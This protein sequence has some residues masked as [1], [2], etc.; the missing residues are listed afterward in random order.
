MEPP[1]NLLPFPGMQ[2]IVLFLLLMTA[3]PLPAVSGRGA[4]VSHSEWT[5]P[6]PK[7]SK[8]TI[9]ALDAAAR[10]ITFLDEEGNEHQGCV[11]DD[12]TIALDGKPVKFDQ[13]HSGFRV[14]LQMRGGAILQVKASSK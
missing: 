7:W 12:T 10:Q 9:S 13:L 14:K 5:K 6:T 4:P 3:V 11:D 1:I 8:G 2:G